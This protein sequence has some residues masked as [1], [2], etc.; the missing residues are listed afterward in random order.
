M[1]DAAEIESRRD[2]A[3]WDG[4]VTE[5]L[6]AAEEAYARHLD[7][8]DRR[9][10]AM[11]AIGT[12]VTLLLRGDEVVGSGW[13][14]R[15]ERLL[16]EL[17]EGPEH[18]YLRYVTEVEGGL[19]GGDFDA[20]VAAAEEVRRIG[21]E[22]GDPNLVAGAATGEGRAK[23][24]RGEVAEGSKL[25]DEAMVAVL[26]GDLDREWAGNIYCHLM[27]ACHEVADVGRAAEWTERT[28]DWLAEQRSAAL[29]TG[30]C[31]VHR[32]QV[33]QSAGSWEQAE[34]EAARVCDELDHLSIESVAE[35]H[36]QLGELKR[37][38]G[39]L[40]EAESAYE[41]ARDRGRDPQ[42]GLAL[43]RL[44][45]GRPDQAAA[46][47]G[48][49][50]RG[51]SDRIGRARLSIA[52]VEIALAQDDLDSARVACAELENAADAYGTSGLEAAALHWRGALVLAEGRPDEALP[53]LR[54]ACR[55]WHRL[56]APYDAARSSVLLARAYRQLGDHDAATSE[57]ASAR[58]AFEQL[59]AG[60]EVRTVE[61]LAAGWSGRGRPL[62]AGLTER[63]AEVLGLVATGKTNR[64]VAEDLTLSEKTI[65]RHL[66]NI[67]T[68]LGV[69]TRTEAAAF[70]YEHGLRRS[71]RAGTDGRDSVPG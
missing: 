62:P 52:Q 46:S 63:E 59:G 22:H 44:T 32:S 65:A 48:A 13:L 53:A 23:L 45:Q 7:E 19:E 1:E 5:Y 33:L 29:F 40:D 12:A 37:L 20:V 41:Q 66:S 58:A 14:G 61:E 16:V 8:D 15:A 67:F 50:I 24:K 11:S 4:R 68:K 42:P 35:A 64:E 57:L 70:A 3:W 30:I 9:A 25:L 38:R 31:R 28:S 39:Q 6:D 55:R 26:H 36:Y 43:L 21:R 10:A 2:A 34:Q 69:A 54:A 18:G 47:I 49:A 71:E 51:A 60:I 56:R 27:A 17:P